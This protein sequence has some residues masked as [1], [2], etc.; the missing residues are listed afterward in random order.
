MCAWYAHLCLTL[1]PHGLQ[2]SRLLCPWDFSG[3]NTGVGCHVLLQKIFPT[4]GMNPHLLWLLHLPV[5]P[6]P[7]SHLGSP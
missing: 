7:L 1:Q 5:D 2:P 3:K 4:Q 6:L